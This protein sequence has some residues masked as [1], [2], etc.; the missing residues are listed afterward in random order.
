MPFDVRAGSSYR[1]GV[2]ALWSSFRSAVNRPTRLMRFFGLVF[3]AAAFL[4]GA[5]PAHA[6]PAGP[7]A[8]RPAVNVTRLAAK[9]GGSAA[10]ADEEPRTLSERRPKNLGELLRRNLVLFGLALGLAAAGLGLVALMVR[11]KP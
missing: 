7:V 4:A 3:L 11:R 1:F 5:S 10:A 2:I 8:D 9:T 6:A